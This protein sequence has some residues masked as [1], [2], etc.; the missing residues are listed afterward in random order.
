MGKYTQNCF[1]KFTGGWFLEPIQK[2]RLDLRTARLLFQVWI[3][4]PQQTE[5]PQD[6]ITFLALRPTDSK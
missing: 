3:E 6:K 1:W 4:W 2:Q 5:W